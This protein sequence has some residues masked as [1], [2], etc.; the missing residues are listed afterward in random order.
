MALAIAFVARRPLLTGA[1][2]AFIVDNP[3]PATYI[4]VLGGGAESRPFTAADLYKRGL[5]PQIVIFEYQRV[6]HPN[7]G[8]DGSQH[9]LY[10]NILLHEG[11]PSDAIVQAPGV[12]RTSW[13]EAMSLRRLLRGGSVPRIVV[14][15]SPEHTRRARWT[16]RRALRPMVG[17]VRT[18]AAPHASF[19]ATN[20]W[21][22]DDGVVLH[23][24]EAVKLP[25]Y[26]V[27]YAFADVD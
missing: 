15:T 11:V 24:H 16:F 26:V 2:R 23:L 13:D 6:L 8:K 7:S 22:S 25:F 19:D 3:A 12:V 10:R 9:I 17:D 5:A 21:R 18:A 14:V 1:A 27:R 4:V 20:W